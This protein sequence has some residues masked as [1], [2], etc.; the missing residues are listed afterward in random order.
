MPGTKADFSK[1]ESASVS[2]P[3]SGVF[4][5]LEKVQDPSLQPWSDRGTSKRSLLSAVRGGGAKST[6][7][8]KAQHLSSC[9]EHLLV[10]HFSQKEDQ[11]NTSIKYRNI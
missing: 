1:A 2:V 6:S 3:G 5:G 10:G 4:F 9:L 11:R 7:G 8:S